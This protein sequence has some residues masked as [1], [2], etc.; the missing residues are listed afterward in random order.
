MTTKAKVEANRRNAQKSTG[1]RTPSGKAIASMNALKHG[2]CAHTP[3][4]PGEDPAE[5]ATFAAGWVDHLQPSDPHQAS[6]AEQ[7]ILA[8]WQLKRVPLLR[9]G[10]LAAEMRWDA[11]RKEPIHP[12][13]IS[14][15]SYV[16]LSRIDRHQVVLERTFRQCLK[17]LKELQTADSADCADYGEEQNEA[18]GTEVPANESVDLKVPL[19]RI[20]DSG[21]RTHDF[22]V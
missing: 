17:E 1:P 18:T 19:A 4:V 3:V 8:A 7:V 22:P 9:A 13:A 16:Q 21:E 6:L 5:F 20:N 14:A 10:L 12:Y 2:L 15:G 11:Q